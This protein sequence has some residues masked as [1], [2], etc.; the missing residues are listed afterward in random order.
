MGIPARLFSWLPLGALLFLISSRSENT[1]NTPLAGSLN[2]VPESSIITINGNDIAWVISTEYGP[3]AGVWVIA[4]TGE[5]DK[6]YA[7][8]VVTDDEGRYLIPDLPDANF[9]VWVRGYGLSDSPKAQSRPGA[10]LDLTAIPV[11]T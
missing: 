4:E 1:D 8:I 9:Q 6:F 5:F 11:A 10:L 3:E 2:S 7:R